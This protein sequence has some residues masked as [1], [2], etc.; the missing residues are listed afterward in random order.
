MDETGISTVPN[1][2]PRVISMRGKRCVSKIASAERGI[3]VTLVSAVNAAGN[4]LPPALIFPRKRLKAELL[5]GASPSSI[6][7][8]FELHQ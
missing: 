4:Y 2:P 5:D 3:N 7:I 8:R 6:G 1:K